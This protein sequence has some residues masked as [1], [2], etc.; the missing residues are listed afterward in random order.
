[1]KNFQSE[2]IV[3]WK[4]SKV[5][6]SETWKGGRRRERKQAGADIPFPS[7]TLDP[8]RAHAVRDNADDADEHAHDDF[9]HDIQ[10]CVRFHTECSRKY[11]FRQ[12][13]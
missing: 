9:D 1:M 2:I 10:F 5:K 8:D 4:I 3:S 6:E 12:V 13:A 7:N 11:K